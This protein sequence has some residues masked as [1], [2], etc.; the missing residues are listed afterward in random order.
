MYPCLRADQIPIRKNAVLDQPDRD[1][2]CVLWVKQ[3]KPLNSKTPDGNHDAAAAFVSPLVH[4]CVCMCVC[5]CSV[6]PGLTFPTVGSSW[7]KHSIKALC[8]CRV[9][10]QLNKAAFPSR[11]LSRLPLDW[12]SETDTLKINLPRDREGYNGFE[13]TDEKLSTR[14]IHC[15]GVPSSVFIFRGIFGE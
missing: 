13:Y 12:P 14:R 5:V 9:S 11:S 7:H 4:V 10:T 1:L 6:L 8:Q 15:C 2:C 3:T